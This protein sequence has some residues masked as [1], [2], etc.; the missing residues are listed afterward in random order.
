MPCHDV[1]PPVGTRHVASAQVGGNQMS[2]VSG[3]TFYVRG[4]DMSR[5]Y[6]WAPGESL[7]RCAC[8]CPTWSRGAAV[9]FTTD[10]ER[11][12]LSDTRT[13]IIFGRAAERAMSE[14]QR[15]TVRTPCPRPPH[16]AP[17]PCRPSSLRD[18]R[19]GGGVMAVRQL[20]TLAIGCR[21][22][23]RSAAPCRPKVRRHGPW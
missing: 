11:S 21:D 12:E 20:A 22:H 8:R 16:S 1:Y 5:P 23:R 13:P 19:G 2:S 10:C 3:N 6:R 18:S 15:S 7:Q 14:W 4:R 17:L 9:V